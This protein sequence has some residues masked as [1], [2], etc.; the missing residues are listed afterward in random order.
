MATGEITMSIHQ[1]KLQADQIQMFYHDEFVESQVKDFSK[2]L[3]P[4]I[5]P[6]EDRV[7]DVGG[8]CGFFAGSLREALGLNV[9]V[10]DTDPQSVAVCQKAGIVAT[11]DDA[12]NPQT[13]GDESIVCFNLILHHLVGR[14]DS[15]TRRLQERALVAWR[16]TARVIYVNEYIYES[17]IIPNLSAWLIYKI[18]SSSALSRIAACVSRYVPSL[19]ANTFGVGVRFR[20]HEQWSRIF[21]SI[22]FHVTNTAIG[23]E[24]Y[25]S[26]PRRLLLI[27]S[28][29]RDSYCLHPKGIN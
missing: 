23:N 7:V 13:V 3:G 14:T 17:F 15:E 24:E 22:G 1:K 25:I 20:S 9:R 16:S 4:S 19:K 11:L 2:L 18:T 26:F 5:D 10:L 29:R 28:C 6:A 8:G 27:K 12:L 21:Q